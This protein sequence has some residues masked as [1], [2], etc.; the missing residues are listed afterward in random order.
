MSRVVPVQ[1]SRRS[2]LVGGAVGLVAACRRTARREVPDPDVAL[3]AAALQREQELL[4]AYQAVLA[5]RPPTAAVLQG[6]AADK[7]VH[8]AALGPAEPVTSTV[9]TVAQLRALEQAAATAHA[10]A[11]ATASRRL[12]PVLA[13][14]AASSSSAAALL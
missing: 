3:R 10:A 7:A 14:L 5:R 12:A 11:A 8:V 13:S 1:P 4:A 2:L 6:L 9:T